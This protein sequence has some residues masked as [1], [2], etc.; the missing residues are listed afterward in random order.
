LER[1]QEKKIERS[2]D[3]EGK[4]SK[5]TSILRAIGNT[6]RLR[7][8]NE[9]SDVHERSVPELE[10]IIATLS[11]LALSQHLGRLRRANNARTR[12]EFQTIY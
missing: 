5:V 6:K 10:N 9:L 11:Q 2:P 3:F 8:P 4:Q 7:I 12:R 1:N